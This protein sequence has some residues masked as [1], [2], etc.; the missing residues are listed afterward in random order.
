MYGNGIM[1]NVRYTS[2]VEADRRRTCQTHG[3]SD[4]GQE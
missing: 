3:G 2:A 1:G 4:C